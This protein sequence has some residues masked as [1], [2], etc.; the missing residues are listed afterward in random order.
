MAIIAGEMMLCAAIV[1]RLAIPAIVLLSGGCGSRFVL[2]SGPGGSTP[3]S[4]GSNYAQNAKTA[5]AV[6]QSWYSPGSGLYASPSGWWNAANSM[7]ALANYARVTGDTSYNSVLANTFAAAQKSHPNF[8]N[9]YYDDQQWWA[10]AW[11][12]AYDATGKADYLSM[13]ETIF[14]NVAANGWDTAACGGG[15]WWNTSKT[16]KNAIPNELFLKL[17]ASLAN[18]TS[19]A[20]SAGYLGWAQKEWAWFKA[21]GM[22]NAENL[23]ND[24]LNSTNPSACTNNGRT[25]WTYNQGVILGGLVELHRADPDATLI[26]EA[27]AI[28]G[29]AMSRLSV[30][31][32]LTEPGKLSGGDGPQFKGIFL[33]NLM[34]LY[35]AIAGTSAQAA[36]YRTFADANAQSIWSSDRNSANQLGGLWQGPFDSA[37]ATRQTSALDALIAAA[38]MK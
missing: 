27:E 22:I 12:D 36:Q 9:D 3:A 37:D 29:A 23:I 34:E 16:Y 5:V 26:P 33:R 30:N 25:T 24:G 1:R 8:I 4:G 19:G 21:S 35:Q 18:R 15:V 11:I 6:L 38:A 10:L 28:A 7:T 20:A 32:I 13:A 17:A 31:G 2:S 14:A